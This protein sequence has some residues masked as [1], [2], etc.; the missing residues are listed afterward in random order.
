MGGVSRII[1]NPVKAVKEIVS[2][3]AQA[4]GLTPQPAP[5]PAPTAAPSAPMQA[6]IPAPEMSPAPAKKPV[7]PKAAVAAP[8]GE[9]QQMAGSYSQ[10]RRRR[11]SVATTSR[12]LTGGAPLER[13]SLLG[14]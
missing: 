1:R 2:P 13:K 9:G 10:R 8:G 4:A 5:A 14:G 12:G 3:V 7:E 11:G 6:P